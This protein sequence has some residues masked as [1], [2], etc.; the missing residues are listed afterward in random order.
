M[1]SVTSILF[2]SAALLISFAQADIVIS[3]TAERPVEAS[4]KTICTTSLLN[5]ETQEK[6]KTIFTIDLSLSAQNM[7]SSDAILITEIH[8]PYYLGNIQF[9]Y[10]GVAGAAESS[11]YEAN[12]AERTYEVT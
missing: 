10:L 1:T 4:R 8:P 12:G 11:S 7:R 6:G 5:K 9:D 3:C 2:I